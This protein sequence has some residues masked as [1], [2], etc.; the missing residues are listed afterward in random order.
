MNMTE[1]K[2]PQDF[3]DRMQRFLKEEY[4]EFLAS[5][6]KERL[7]GLRFNPLKTE[8]EEFLK[9]VPFALEPVA[10]TQEGFYYESESQPGRHP[11]HEA[12]VYYIQEPSA[13]AAAEVLAPM[14]GERILDL[15][16]AP[17]G[18]S[19]HIA[20]KMAGEGLLVSNEIITGRAKILS[21]NIERMGI[22]NTVVCN[23]EPE[24]MAE[25]FPLFFDRILVDAPC[26]GEGMF[27]KEEAALSEWTLDNV[28]MCADRQKMILRQAA[29]MLKPG[30][31]LVYS[32]CTF[33]PEENEGVVCAFLKEH[34]DFRIEETVQEHFFSPGRSE[35]TAGME[36]IDSSAVGITH[37]MRLFPHKIAGE[38]HFIAKLRK[39]EKPYI[40]YTREVSAADAAIRKKGKE[41]RERKDY[42]DTDGILLC[43]SFLEEELGFTKEIWEKIEKNG[44][45][46]AFGEH[47][48]VMPR[49][50]I[51]LKGLKVLRPGLQLGTVKKN[52]FEPSHA[53]ALYLSPNDVNRNC[54]MS[55]QQTERYLR[56]E[57]FACDAQ[58]K[59][60]TLLSVEGYSI[61]FGKAGGGLMKNHYPK[62]LRRQ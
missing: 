62:G 46:Q 31:V 32:T 6:D 41:Q 15:C 49:Q 9:R 60:W 29:R 17:G 19:T 45:M 30:G 39:E 4:P 61:G 24:R 26:S 23:E 34:P 22:A 52:R 20:G 12:G 18:K 59:G 11:F 44:I 37:T 33:S 58:Q 8:R 40:S 43:R 21:Q 42:R 13:M 16:A 25:F 10:W 53:L 56:G 3:K 51:P 55:L 14:P 47:V 35:W 2:L 48:Y 5:Y 28:K 38:G 54:E 57:T 1:R 7:Y 27:R 50:M 36:G